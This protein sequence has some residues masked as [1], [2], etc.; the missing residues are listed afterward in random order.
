VLAFIEISKN[1]LK[2]LYYTPEQLSEQTLIYLSSITAHLSSLQNA[3]DDPLKLLLA[4]ELLIHLITFFD[5]TRYQ[6]LKP[7]LLA[8]IA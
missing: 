8:C 2:Y 3:L 5:S 6:P 7:T 1:F 4:E